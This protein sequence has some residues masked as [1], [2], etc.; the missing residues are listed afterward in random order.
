MDGSNASGI[1]FDP[2]HRIGTRFEAGSD[3]ELQHHCPLG[4][5]GEHLDGTL[6]FHCRE[7]RGMVVISNS[8]ATGFEL[9]ICFIQ[10]IS[11]RLPAIESRLRIRPRQHNIFAS[12]DQIAVTRL[13][14]IFSCEGWQT[15]VRGITLD[16]QVIYQL[17]H[18]FRLRFRPVVVRRIELDGLV[19]HLGDGAHSAFEI[20]LQSVA[21]RVEFEP[22]RN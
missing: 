21:N 13:L 16:P 11:Q 19:S 10:L 18:L 12:Q 3:I 20:S 17:A 14:D 5:G 15:I 22:N 9:G 1:G 2:C 8:Q 6:P 4:V 7:F